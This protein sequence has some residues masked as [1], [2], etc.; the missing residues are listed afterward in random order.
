VD[1]EP[2]MRAALRRSLYQANA[3]FLEAGDG[4]E[5]VGLL[6]DHPVDAVISDFEMPRMDGLELLQY[7]RLRLPQVLRIMLTARA[8][9]NVA[10]RA[11]NEGRCTASCS[12]PGTGS[13]CA[14]SSTWAC[15]AAAASRSGA[16]EM[17]AVARQPRV[18]ARRPAAE[19]PAT[20]V[21]SVLVV[22]DDPAVRRM[23]AGPCAITACGCVRPPAAARP[24]SWPR[25]RRR[26]W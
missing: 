12:S 20:D 13:T 16:I 3:T 5:A 22:D 4:L 2:D 25:P 23:L 17:L 11:L 14:A 19:Q 18:P 8:D 9:V 26:T 7:V 24:W 10:V 6:R 1:D 21:G 15:G